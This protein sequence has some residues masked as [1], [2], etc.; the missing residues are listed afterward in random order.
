LVVTDLKEIDAM[1]KDHKSTG[2]VSE[3]D[4]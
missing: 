3:M 2:R 4:R 1:I